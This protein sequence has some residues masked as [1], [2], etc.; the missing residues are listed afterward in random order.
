MKIKV[1]KRAGE[2]VITG[3]NCDSKKIRI[4]DWLIFLFCILFLGTTH[5]FVWHKIAYIDHI[6]SFFGTSIRQANQLESASIGLLNSKI[7]LDYY[8]KNQSLTF[9]GQNLNSWLND[10]VTNYNY[11]T[12][13]PI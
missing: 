4:G 7:F 6:E 2:I 8:P 1:R 3:S 10:W 11:T 13:Y 5:A 9:L 12:D